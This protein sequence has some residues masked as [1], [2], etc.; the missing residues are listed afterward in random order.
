M[1]K[2]RPRVSSSCSKKMA[3]RPPPFA[4]FSTCRTVGPGPHHAQRTPR[5]SYL[6]ISRHRHAIVPD[7]ATV[8]L[9]GTAASNVLGSHGSVALLAAARAGARVSRSSSGSN[10][11]RSASSTGGLLTRTLSEAGKRWQLETRQV[12]LP[13]MRAIEEENAALRA[14]VAR[15]KARADAAEHLLR[16]ARARVTSALATG[17][18]M[19]GGIEVTSEVSATAAVLPTHAGL[20]T[21]S[22]DDGVPPIAEEQ[23]IQL[24]AHQPSASALASDPNALVSAH[25]LDEEN[26][27]AMPH[28]DGELSHSH[29]LTLTESVGHGKQVPAHDEPVHEG[30]VHE[31]PAHERPAHEQGWDGPLGV[32]RDC[33]DSIAATVCTS[34]QEPVATVS[35]ELGRAD[36]PA[37]SHLSLE[38]GLSAATVPAV[39]VSEASRAE[40][41]A[42]PRQA[43]HRVEA[44][45]TVVH[46]RGAYSP[47]GTTNTALSR[48][49]LGSTA[50]S[51]KRTASLR[52]Q[53]P[54]AMASTT[55]A[56]ASAS[57]SASSS[58]TPRPTTLRGGRS[59]AQ[60]ERALGSATS[61]VAGVPAQPQR[62][63]MR[64]S[65][66][67]AAGPA[68]DPAVAGTRPSP[69]SS[70]GR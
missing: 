17:R 12:I 20:S 35:S 66:A 33:D 68:K 26:E 9:R 37:A 25:D 59:E 53:P 49:A 70:R 69:T 3:E 2:M 45:L 48:E 52:P 1:K 55:T 41:A 42:S 19:E 22:D 65:A 32:Q 51:G 5:N 8:Q 60:R 31:R 64:S 44:P 29:E 43:D 27:G 15:L 38:G 57:G 10:L 24:S 6:D 36:K 16:E 23:V 56:A 54:P 46:P 34:I 11:I 58:I 63:S 28:R 4:E 21:A 39:D 67:G 50:G 61:S 13:E 18:A 14:D 40:G 47:R 62:M 7:G 30:V